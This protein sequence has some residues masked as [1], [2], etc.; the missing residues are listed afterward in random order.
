MQER[1]RVVDKDEIIV[2]FEMSSDYRIRPLAVCT[3]R[4]RLLCP[5]GNSF[6]PLPPRRRS[7]G[8]IISSTWPFNLL[9]DGQKVSR[10]YDCEV[11]RKLNV[12]SIG[13]NTRKTLHYLAEPDKVGVCVAR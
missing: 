10:P 11:C 1:K 3:N 6:F 2:K 5:R 12:E 9:N 7:A 4:E 13:T 8:F